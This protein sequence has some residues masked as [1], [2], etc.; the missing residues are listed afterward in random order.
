MNLE[1]SPDGLNIT[2]STGSGKAEALNDGLHRMSEAGLEFHVIDVAEELAAM[3]GQSTQSEKQ[4]GCS[5]IKKWQERQFK[6]LLSCC[7]FG[8]STGARTPD[9]PVKSRVLCQLS[10]GRV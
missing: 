5:L 3:Q 1:K 6:P 8:A 2:N 4:L 10:Y 9:V 7:F